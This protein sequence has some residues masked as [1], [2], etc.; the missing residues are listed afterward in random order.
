MNSVIFLIIGVILLILLWAGSRRS[1]DSASPPDSSEYLVQLPSSSLFARCLSEEDVRFVASVRSASLSR[2]LRRERRRLALRWLQLT[3]REA[4]RL[5]GLHVR[6][7][8][9]AADL[10]PLTEI[11]LV[12]EL[13]WFLVIYQALTGLVHLYGPFRTQAYVRS[14]QRL[15]IVLAQLGG[16]IAASAGPSPV[17]ELQTARGE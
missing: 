4:T 13:G 5:F 1:T 14:I 3:R 9:Y 11:K 17:A 7:A 2:L 16:R 6:A 12:L 10:R 8:R 15:A